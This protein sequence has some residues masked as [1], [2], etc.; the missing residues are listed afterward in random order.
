MKTKKCRACGKTFRP[1]S[2]LQK[3]CS[4]DCAIKLVDDRK[5]KEYKRETLQLKRNFKSRDKRFWLDKARKACHDYIKYRDRH[6]PCISC[7]RYTK[8]QWHAG[9]YRSRGAASQLQFHWSNIWKQCAHCN[10]YK[11]GNLV[12]YRENLIK[13][14]SPELVEYLDN[15]NSSYK[16]T[17]DDYKGVY[18]WFKAQIG[19][20]KSTES[21]DLI[22]FDLDQGSKKSP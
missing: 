1:W 18:E 21:D 16:W 6:L 17:I 19:A 20:L 11:S 9:H 12:Q 4:P 10:T 22:S 15:E 13:R 2:S 14:T 5:K 7:G 3:A 8:G